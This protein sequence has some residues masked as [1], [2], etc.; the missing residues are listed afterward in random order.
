MTLNAIGIGLPAGLAGWKLLQGKAPE[1]FRA[2]SKNPVLQR[3]IA[4]LRESLPSKLTPGEL[5]ADRRLQQM[6]LQ[7]YGLDAQIGFDGLMRKVLSS[8]PADQNSVAARMTDQRFRQIA[9]DLNYGGAA[10]AAV[11]A[12]PSGARVEIEWGKSGAGFTSLTGSF[13]TVQ[14]RDVPLSGLT[15]RA[16]LASALQQA[17]RKADGGRSDISVTAFGLELVLSDA[18]GRGA[19]RFDF[20]PASGSAARA[21]TQAG[22]TAS[23][24]QATIAL[25]GLQAGQ[26]FSSFSGS[27]GT[28]AVEAVPLGGLS[29]AEAVA[30]ALQAAFRKAD[31]GRGDISV[32]AQGQTLV[33]TDARDRR[34]PQLAFAGTGTSTGGATAK[35]GKA[36]D[37]KPAIAATG[38]PKVADSALVE[39]I[40]QKYT[41]AK[42]EETLGN[43]S[44]SLRRAVY[45]KRM[46]PQVTS[47]YS[48]IADR[49]LAAVVQT[50]MGLPDSF[51]RLDVDQQKAALEK[52]MSIADFKDSTK[53]GKLLERYVG[54]SSVAEAR[55]LA[56]SSGIVSLV[57][58]IFR[59][60]SFSG[61]SS[62]ALFS[63][64]SGR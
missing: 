5:L 59:G 19:A 10:T 47:W 34:A 16:E 20:A 37:G 56:S 30:A 26:G 24:L 12:T 23:P 58:P 53:L 52:R 62:A 61:A 11:P 50:V 28:V 57:Q 41:Q 22:G 44:E 17:F 25:S 55:A 36:V 6:V 13:G 21:V 9:R 29:G 39:A 43:S 63:I 51:G 54:Q 45:A 31:G 49:N 42:F 35:L 4:Y 64:L 27:F 40:V 48:V 33:L 60:D 38:G 8:D 2:F 18:R 15:T 46:L 3:D 14:V 7:A 32:A 1:D